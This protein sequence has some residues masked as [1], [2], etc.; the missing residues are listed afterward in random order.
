MSRAERR[1]L[2]RQA[3]KSK[4]DDDPAS[5]KA[6]VQACYTAGDLKSA[7]HLM[8]RLLGHTPNDPAALGFAGMLANA[9][10][11]SRK[12]FDHYSAAYA[13]K[14]SNTLDDLIAET[15]Q[16]AMHAA[17]A[18][19]TCA[20]VPKLAEQLLARN[21]QSLEAVAFQAI[22]LVH[23]GRRDEAVELLGMDTLVEIRDL[24]PPDGWQSMDEFN[25]SLAE[26]MS[27]DPSMAVPEETHPTY[28]NR[29]LKI[30]SP[31]DIERVGPIAALTRKIEEAVAEYRASR[32]ES[33]HPFLARWPDQSRLEAWG[34]LLEGEGTVDAHLH[35]EGYLGMVYYPELPP[36]VEDGQGWLELG[37]PPD[38]F[39]LEIDAITKLIKP[40][41]GRLVMFPG[42]LFHRTTPFNSRHRR[43][44][45]AYDVVVR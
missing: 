35:L 14:P 27:A 15:L 20:D 9:T 10:G 44:S 8:E 42:Y 40:V 33:D 23:Q 2:S 4:I 38:D 21:P 43:I 30:T 12:A 32:S 29:H 25:A 31:L 24:S 37:R 28:H 17:M 34:T 11:D 3:K 6:A 26:T 22:A 7:N 16:P 39:P 19:D 18:P 13:I 36:E 41:P 5:L 1:R 45:V